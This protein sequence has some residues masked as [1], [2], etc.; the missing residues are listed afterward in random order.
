MF[1]N[2]QLSTHIY[3]DVESDSSYFAFWILFFLFLLDT[4]LVTDFLVVWNGKWKNI[5]K[6]CNVEMVAHTEWMAYTNSFRV[7]SIKKN[8]TDNILHIHLVVFSLPYASVSTQRTI[9]TYTNYEQICWT[10][11]V[12]NI[13]PKIPDFNKIHGKREQ[14]KAKK[15]SNICW[16]ESMWTMWIWCVSSASAQHFRREKKRK[17]LLLKWLKTFHIHRIPD[18]M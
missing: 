4:N 13:H 17:Y 6:I 15:H 7:Q 10:K 8:K 9:Y 5:W 16:A 11:L 2:C 14:K 18:E 1:A 3:A 12:E